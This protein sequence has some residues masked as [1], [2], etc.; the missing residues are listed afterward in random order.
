MITQLY[1]VFDSKAQIY[2]KPFH[3]H[4]HTVA[5]RAARDLLS[6]DNEISRHPE[7]FA[8]FHIGEYND[9]TAHIKITD[10]QDCIVRFHELKAIMPTTN[11]NEEAA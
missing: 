3:F 10:R 4:N 7:D 11:T 8:M 2:N 9:E 5:V 1:V 6:E